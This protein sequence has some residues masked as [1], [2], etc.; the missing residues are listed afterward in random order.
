MASK[1]EKLAMMRLQNEKKKEEEQNAEVSLVTEFVENVKAE[2]NAV[3]D[4]PVSGSSSSEAGQI[5]AENADAV[6]QLNSLPDHKDPLLKTNEKIE[7]PVKA[8]SKRERA[9]TTILL[10]LHDPDK[11][12][13]LEFMARSKKMT[14]TKYIT[15]LI[16][17]DY[18][19]YQEAFQ[20][21]KRL[22]ILM[23]Q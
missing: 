13:F 20:A 6:H 17:N 19:K 4:I 21:Y 5:S 9:Q 18:V 15:S 7:D 3:H 22:T 1:R 11:K 8:V 10:D 16:D 12:E 2:E 23:R 14:M